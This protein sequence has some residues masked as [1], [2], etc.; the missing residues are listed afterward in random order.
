MKYFFLTILLL[1]FSCDKIITGTVYNADLDVCYGVKDVENVVPPY[2]CTNMCIN[3]SCP[4]AYVVYQC[5]SDDKMLNI[6]SSFKGIRITK[7]R[8][9]GKE[10]AGT[11]SSAEKVCNWGNITRPCEEGFNKVIEERCY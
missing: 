7:Y 8:V 11:Y 5:V 1:I 3:F 2:I 4:P 10:V 6:V 9:D